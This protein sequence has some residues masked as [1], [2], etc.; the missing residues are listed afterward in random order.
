MRVR[1]GEFEL[2]EETRE[3]RRGG[4]RIEIRPKVLQLV[5]ALVQVR[6]HAVSRAALSDRLWPGTAVAYTSLPGVVAEL[7]RALGDDPAK[8]RFVRTIRGFGYAFIANP[9]LAD[10]EPVLATGLRCA[11]MWSGREVGLPDGDTLIG[12][13]EDCA[14]R[15]DSGRISR[16]HARIVVDGDGTATIEDLGSKN[17]T[18]LRGRRLT[19]AADLLDGDEI[20]VGSA[21]L[22]FRAG[23]GPG[24]T[25]T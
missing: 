3:L 10:P 22:V 15:I 1:F 20:A 18:F 14:V 5:E 7:R 13:A 11:L 2:D 23:F 12:R 4:R 25:V 16:H 17:G 21:L 9:V 6:P 8:P 24:S 19:G